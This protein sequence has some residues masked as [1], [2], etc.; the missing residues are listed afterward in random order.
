M[1]L[2]N[3]GTFESIHSFMLQFFGRRKSSFGF[4]LNNHDWCFKIKNQNVCFQITCSFICAYNSVSCAC[5]RYLDARKGATGDEGWEECVLYCPNFSLAR[6]LDALKPDCPTN[7][8]GLFHGL[9]KQKHG[10]SAGPTVAGCCSSRFIS[11]SQTLLVLQLPVTTD[12]WPSAN[13]SCSIQSFIYDRH[14]PPE[15]ILSL[16]APNDV[17]DVHGKGWQC[18]G[19]MWDRDWRCDRGMRQ[20]CR[21]NEDERNSL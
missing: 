2:S 13:K 9:R 21:M 3:C 19:N 6:F 16:E 20:Q 15:L 5:G 7:V 18:G 8:L 11:L 17:G 1:Q 12:T 10:S 14:F 4:M